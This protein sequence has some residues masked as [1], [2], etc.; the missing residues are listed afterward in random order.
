[1]YPLG[2]LMYSVG[3]KGKAE[4]DVEFFYRELVVERASVK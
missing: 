4:N 3:L 2:R 1:M